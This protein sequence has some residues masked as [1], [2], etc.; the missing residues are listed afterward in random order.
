MKKPGLK[1]IKT[2]RVI[3]QGQNPTESLRVELFIPSD[4]FYMKYVPLT[5]VDVE[6]SSSQ[7]KNILKPNCSIF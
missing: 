7:Y 3:H 2:I 5:S 4:A 1:D 6:H